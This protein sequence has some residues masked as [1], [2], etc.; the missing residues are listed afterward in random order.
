M[1]LIKVEMFTVVCDICKKSADEGTDYSCWN[2]ENAAKEAA[3][4][5]EYLNEGDEHYCPNCYEYD[6][7]DN[8]VLKSVQ[9]L[10]S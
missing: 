8:L 5:A 7:E 9:L 1:S 4:N 10:D 6:D 2:D 3:M